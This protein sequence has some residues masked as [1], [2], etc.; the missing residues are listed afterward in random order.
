MET[1][2]KSTIKSI[3]ADQI[4]KSNAVADSFDPELI[5]E[6]VLKRFLF[7]NLKELPGVPES[8]VPSGSEDLSLLGKIKND[9]DTIRNSST[10]EENQVPAEEPKTEEVVEATVPVTEAPAEVAPVEKTQ[11]EVKLDA[12]TESVTK[13]FEKIEEVNLKCT[14]VQALIKGL[15]AP[16]AVPSLE[17][18]ETKLDAMEVSVT[19]VKA[20]LEQVSRVSTEGVSK[21]VD[22]YVAE[23]QLK[24]VQK[25]KSKFW[26]SEL[27]P[28]KEIDLGGQK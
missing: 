22:A 6:E 11:V 2:I 5:E 25:A 3:V 8:I 13:L 1:T 12:L 23:E 18:L 28:E 15:P 17:G 19:E 24:A 9:T 14:D 7:S 4:E 16:A 10:M 26:V 20:T 21:L 27:V